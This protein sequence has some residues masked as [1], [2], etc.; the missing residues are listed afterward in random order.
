MVH[1]MCAALLN[2]KVLPQML[3]RGVRNSDD[4][5]G[6]ARILRNQ[7]AVAE[8]IAQKRPSKARRTNRDRG[9]PIRSGIL[10]LRESENLS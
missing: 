4:R 10:R 9:R 1:R 2:R 8:A 6:F 7:K 3:F 5:T